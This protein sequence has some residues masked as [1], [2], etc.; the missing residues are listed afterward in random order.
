MCILWKSGLWST[1]WVD[2]TRW[3]STRRGHV[4]TV[5]QSFPALGHCAGCCGELGGAGAPLRDLVLSLS[6]QSGGKRGPDGH[7]VRPPETLVLL[8][9]LVGSEALL[10]LSTR[11]PGGSVTLHSAPPTK[12]VPAS[13]VWRAWQQ[14]FIS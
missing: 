8:S 11:G 6:R 9:G 5:L 10:A 14:A 4:D 13:A 12:E 7:A 2:H 3:S 1:E